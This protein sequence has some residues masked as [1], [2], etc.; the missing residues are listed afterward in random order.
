MCVCDNGQLANGFKISTRVKTFMINH[1]YKC[2][3]IHNPHS[4]AKNIIHEFY[5]KYWEDYNNNI[6]INFLSNGVNKSGNDYQTYLNQY[7]NYYVF[8]CVRNPWDRF[9]EGW[10]S[11]RKLRNK[12]LDE[13]LDNMPI[14]D[15]RFNAKSIANREWTDI[16][17]T[18]TDCLYKNNALVPNFVIKYE[19]LQTDFDT[20]CDSIKRT[21]TDLDIL[22]IFDSYDTNYQSIFTTQSQKD[23][24]VSHF[25]QDITNFGYTF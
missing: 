11:S 21:K 12:T 22:S 9:V 24:F 13:V 20:V 25:Q 8:A 2:I 7:S 16:S 14:Y 3:F 15:N 1:Q 23:K 6:L 4:G 19:N 17:Q 5:P 10:K 18:Q